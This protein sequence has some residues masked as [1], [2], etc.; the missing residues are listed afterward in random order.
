[1]SARLSRLNLVIGSHRRRVGYCT[2]RIR[3]S[4]PVP[5]NA[6]PNELSDGRPLTNSS[7]CVSVGDTGCVD[8]GSLAQHRRDPAMCGPSPKGAVAAYDADCSIHT[9]EIGVNG[10]ST[11]SSSTGP[12]CTTSASLSPAIFALPHG[13]IPGS[14]KLTRLRS[15]SSRSRPWTREQVHHVMCCG[16][17]QARRDGLSGISTV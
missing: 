8:S 11:C 10:I 13:Q 15:S 17:A 4:I 1:M 9:P 3:I 2:L 5:T 12:S 16:C 7:P 14:F 6:R